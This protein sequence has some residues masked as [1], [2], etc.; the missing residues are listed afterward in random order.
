MQSLS[1]ERV[2]EFNQELLELANSG[3]VLELGFQ[4]PSFTSQALNNVM[5]KLASDLDRGLS[6]EQAFATAPYLTNRYRQTFFDWLERGPAEAAL[7]GPAQASLAMSR[8]RGEMQGALIQPVIVVVIAYCALLYLF[9]TAVPYLEEI[10]QRAAVAPGRVLEWLI[11]VRQWM[12]VWSV[13]APVVAVAC[14][15]GLSLWLRRTDFR[16]L[17]G[18]R[19]YFGALEN[20]IA[21]ERLAHFNISH[22]AE[23][24]S[25]EVAGPRAADDMEVAVDANTADSRRKSWPVTVSQVQRQL[26]CNL[27]TDQIRPLL[28]WATSEL[29]A[30][31]NRAEALRQAASIYR[32]IAHQQLWLWRAWIPTMIGVSIGGVCVLVYGL[33]LFLPVIEL[34]YELTQSLRAN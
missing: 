8:V 29:V 20:A 30:D 11:V 13:A 23:C 34:L 7:D 6:I 15:F 32:Q 24:A 10:H 3:V 5:Q 27:S 21:A 28:H 4:S 31:S 1:L 16:W 22:T 33:C 26:D 12:P 17:P 19:H 9:F 18:S 14:I 2:R 25:S